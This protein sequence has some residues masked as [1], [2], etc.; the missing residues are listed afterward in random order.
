MKQ[1]VT[2]KIMASIVAVVMFALVPGECAGAAQKPT[3]KKTSFSESELRALAKAF[4]DVKNAGQL[5]SVAL[6]TSNDADRQQAYLK[7]SAAGLIACGKTDIYKK[8]IKGK[9][10]NVAEFE[11]GL[12]D[13]C[14][15]CS[16][17]GT[18]ERRCYD[19]KGE[20][21]CPG[22]K[23]SGETV[24]VGFNVGFN[25]NNETKPCR[26]CKG[27]GRCPKCGGEGSTREKCLSCS[28]TGR[29]LSKTVAA[30]VFRDSCNA[31]ADGV[32]IVA[33]QNK[34]KNNSEVNVKPEDAGKP[35]EKH[36][37]LLSAVKETAVEK[38]RMPAKPIDSEKGRIKVQNKGNTVGSSINASVDSRKNS[39]GLSAASRRRRGSSDHASASVGPVKDGFGTETIDGITYSFKISNGEAIIGKG[40]GFVAAVKGET[41][42]TIFVP[43]KL[44]GAPVTKIGFAAF[45]KTKSAKIVLPDS[46]VVLESD[47]FYG[48]NASC[49]VI[50]DTVQSVA[51]DALNDTTW[52]ENQ[53]DGPLYLDHVFLG[54]KN[55]DSKEGLFSVREG[56]K[57]IASDAFSLT[58]FSEVM[59]PDSVCY[60][61]ESAFSGC[62][63]LTR[64]TIPK[65]LV[66][67]GRCAFHDCDAL[68]T[69]LIFSDGIREIGESAF[70]G[71]SKIERVSLPLSIKTIGNDAFHHC[72]IKHIT[73]PPLFAATDNRGK[74]I[75]EIPNSVESVKLIGQWTTI[76]D[77]L[78]SQLRELKK[79]TLPE[80]VVRIGSEAFEYCEALE[81][82]YIPDTV[83]AIGNSAFSNCKRMRNVKLPAQLKCIKEFLFSHCSSLEA[84]FI[85]LGVTNI[86][87]HAFYDC[88]SLK[89]ISIPDSVDIIADNAF[90]ETCRLQK[91]E[92]RRAADR[93]AVVRK[94]EKSF[95]KDC[96]VD[97]EY[98]QVEYYGVYYAIVKNTLGEDNFV[99]VSGIDNP[100]GYTYSFMIFPTSDSHDQWY[101]A[102]VKCT[103]KLTSWIRI[104][105]KNKVKHVS[106]EIPIY[107]D[108]N[109]DEV[110]AIANGITGGSGQ[111]E[112]LRKAIRESVTLSNA[113]LVKFIGT[114]DTTDD[115]FKRYRISIRMICGDHF[116]R[117]IFCK[118][119][120]AEEIDNEIVK[121]LTFVNPRSLKTARKMQSEKEDMF[122]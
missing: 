82:I 116:S 111:S 78:F 112:L 35:E 7:A 92:N 12:K 79:L 114:V 113:Q 67:I 37:K 71:C 40:G 15:K 31:I 104:S 3:A 77:E 119:G 49:I 59:L 83:M 105:A 9:L 120:T 50:P 63:K 42:A 38:N 32:G 62:S 103:E 8:H 24:R 47:A 96:A 64:I 20:G 41:S 6:A 81:E 1:R 56:T 25:N 48:A 34:T 115:T 61:G 99:A 17:A 11:D 88:P 23:G 118:A 87:S 73:L 30:R 70:S 72:Q 110:Y 45:Y 86:E 52:Y 80:S 89:K 95:A 60:L 14:E 93:L 44:G 74:V 102:I 36:P 4:P 94:A 22:C 109:V 46:V 28:G 108:G 98:A 53:K 2:I 43:Q 55:C 91:S 5:Y 54:F 66:S 97:S 57:V 122:R 13:D 26:K 100:N 19:C 117:Q 69:D 107:K 29:V 106:K 75:V 68:V 18:K 33:P 27:S 21:K 85:P 90:D 58:D 76:P 16:G 39:I 84:V 101:A 51:H 10:Q 121:L 65:Y